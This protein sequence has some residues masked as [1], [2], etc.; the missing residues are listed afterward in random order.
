LTVQFTDL[1]VAGTSPIIAW[2]WSFGDGDTSIVA[3]PSH[4][5]TTPGSYTV[6]L[7]VLTNDGEDR[8]DKAFYITVVAPLAINP[9]PQFS[10]TRRREPLLLR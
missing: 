4:I 8:E 6:V 3:S 10:A 2:L 9:A 5:Y 7:S 1:S